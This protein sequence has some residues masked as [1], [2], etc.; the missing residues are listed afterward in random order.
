MQRIIMVQLIFEFILLGIIG[1]LLG[2]FYMNC[3]KAE[4]M[5]FNGLYYRVLK[6]WAELE[7]DLEEQC[8]YYQLSF[9]DKIRKW[10][11]Y[12]L[13]YCVYCSSTWI[14]L[15]LCGISLSAW[16]V[17]PKWQD[18]TIGIIAAVAI[19]HLVVA[20]I[21]RFVIYKHPDLYE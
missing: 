1:G 5:I 4:G 11:A 20:S 10:I 19:Q 3:L 14:T 15:I 8:I 13:G 21:C 16:E 12:P 7:D 9:A 17:L 2:I 18:I 6:P